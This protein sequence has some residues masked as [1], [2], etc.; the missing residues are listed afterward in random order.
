[1]T[2]V[3]GAF[4]KREVV[5]SYTKFDVLEVKESENRGDRSVIKVLL[6]S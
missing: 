3:R 6:S 4:Q 5:I 2:R 1:M